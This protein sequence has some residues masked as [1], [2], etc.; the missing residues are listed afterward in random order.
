[1]RHL[2]RVGIVAIFLSVTTAYADTI[3]F[4]AILPLTG[5]GA[6]IGTEQMRGIQF[7]VDKAN[8]YRVWRSGESLDPS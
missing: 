5:P 2:L 7:A 6:V 8:S 3:R 4:G 1:M